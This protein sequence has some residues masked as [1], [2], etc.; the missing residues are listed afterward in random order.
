MKQITAQK[1][2]DKHLSFFKNAPPIP[3]KGW[4][5]AIRDAIGMTAQQLANRLNIAQSNITNLEKHEVHQSITLA[6][7]EKI[8]QSLNCRLVYAI[9][10]EHSL[11]SM[12]QKQAH[13]KAKEF[14]YSINRTM[15]LEAQNLSPEALN[16]EY[17][18]LVAELSKNIRRLWD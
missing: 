4:I 2:L 18:L 9:V 1:A 8:A 6:S 14:F 16:E 7:L 3:P 17:E 15:T 13:I 10:P 12:V 11:E 5:R